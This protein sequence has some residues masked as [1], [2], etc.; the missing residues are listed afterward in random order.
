L[1]KDQLHDLLEY[2]NDEGRIC[3]EPSKWHQLW[4]MLPDKNRVG[5]G[6]NPPLPLIL[7]A[8]DHTTGLEKMLRLKQHIEY[9]TE[10]GVL[11]NV[12]QFLRN[13]PEEEWH[14][15]EK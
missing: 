1:K 9:A 14:T 13:L 11:D 6:W 12:E 10:K 4:E 8:W 15:V 3:P 7:A 2:V 5:S